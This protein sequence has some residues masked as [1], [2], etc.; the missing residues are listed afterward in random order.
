MWTV[1]EY[2]I[3][4]EYPKQLKAWLTHGCNDEGVVYDTVGTDC[5]EDLHF[6]KECY[7]LHPGMMS[8]DDSLWT[9]GV[10]DM[11]KPKSMVDLLKENPK[12]LTSA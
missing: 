12:K 3:P 4:V 9:R 1:L 10:Q 8:V 2:L 7:N 6:I 5:K 11:S